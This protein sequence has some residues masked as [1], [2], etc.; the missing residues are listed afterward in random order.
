MSLVVV[1]LIAAVDIIR[2]SAFAAGVDRI[3]T[4]SISSCEVVFA[5]RAGSRIGRCIAQG[6]ATH[7]L[8]STIGAMA[9]RLAFVPTVGELL[10]GESNETGALAAGAL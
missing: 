10:F 7:C 1:I 6:L 2:I 9:M 3:T 8:A 4:S 5:P